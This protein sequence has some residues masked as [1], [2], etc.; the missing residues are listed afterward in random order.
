MKIKPLGNRALLKPLEIEEKTKSGL[1]I[2]ESAKENLLQAEVI[3]VGDGKDV[4]VKV[5][6]RVIYES[7]GG[8]EIKIS[9][10]KHI[11]IDVKD[12]LAVVE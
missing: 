4:K 11:I 12:I 7:F 9:E 10:Q 3:A 8:S 1:Y 6:D 5:G 2:P